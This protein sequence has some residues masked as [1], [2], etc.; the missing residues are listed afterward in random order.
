MRCF[1]VSLLGES[2][3]GLQ[4]VGDCLRYDNWPPFH[5]GGQGETGFVRG[6]VELWVLLGMVSA[7]WGREELPVLVS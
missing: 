2:I 6:G 5:D 1:S 4:N 7:G 3:C